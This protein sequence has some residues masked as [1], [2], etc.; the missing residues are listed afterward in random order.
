M[1]AYIYDYRCAIN[2][3]NRQRLCEVRLGGL[4]RRNL[5]LTIILLDK[6][7]EN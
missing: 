6:A 2:Y 3:S 7:L 5:I 4:R 1:L